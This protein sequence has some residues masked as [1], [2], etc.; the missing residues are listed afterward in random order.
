MVYVPIVLALLGLW[1]GLKL[2]PDCLARL[3]FS[4]PSRGFKYYLVWPWAG[5]LR[6]H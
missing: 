2:I 5:F 6:A 1:L 3:E 4:S